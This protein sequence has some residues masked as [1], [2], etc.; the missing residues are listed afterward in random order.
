[1]KKNIMLLIGGL[2]LLVGCGNQ[3]AKN[4]P[5]EPKWKG[6]PYRL[7]FDTQAAKPNPASI[8]IPPI[9][10]TANPDA[11]ENRAMLV[12]QFEASGPTTKELVVK[13]MIGLPTDIHGTEGT[14]PA[15]YLAQASKSL[16]D[17]LGDHCLNGQVKLSVALTRSSLKPAAEDAE[18]DAMRLS[19]WQP[20]DLIY[21]NPHLKCR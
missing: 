10:Y 5:A 2:A 6:A 3:G 9:K 20:I 13:R 14:L 1:V 11:V 12:L 4:A 15:D 16:S 7:V 19:D 21:K 8:T 18:I 17:Y